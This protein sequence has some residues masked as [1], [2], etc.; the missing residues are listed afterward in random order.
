MLEVVPV[1]LEQIVALGGG[2]ETLAPLC[3]FLAFQLPLPSPIPPN[4]PMIGGNCFA[5]AMGAVLLTALIFWI[6]VD[7]E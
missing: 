3:G 2:I 4:S 7:K 1:S 5:F 6:L